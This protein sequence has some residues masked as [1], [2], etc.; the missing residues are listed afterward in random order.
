VVVA[1]GDGS[2]KLF[3]LGSAGNGPIQN[4]HEHS[5]EVYATSWNLVTK[6]T[7]VTSSWD[8]TIKLVRVFPASSPRFEQEKQLTSLDSGLRNV[9]NPLPLFRPTLAHTPLPSPLTLRRSYLRFPLIVI[10]ES[11]TSELRLQPLTT[12]FNLFQSMV[13]LRPW[14]LPSMPIDLLRPCRLKH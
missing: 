1:C 13:R 10:S 7:F 6:D 5:R 9:L 11:S 4:F 3:D 14:D 2:V 8:G 12:W